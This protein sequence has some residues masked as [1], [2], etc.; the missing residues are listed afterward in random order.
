MKQ[1]DVIRRYESYVPVGSV[2]E[3]IVGR[4]AIAKFGVDYRSEQKAY[5]RPKED[6]GQ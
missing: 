2:A 5:A 1:F 6:E 3:R 4:A